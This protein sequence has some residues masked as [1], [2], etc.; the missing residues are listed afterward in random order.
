[1]DKAIVIPFSIEKIDRLRN[2]WNLYD[3]QS[4]IELLG[5]DYSDLDP[6][7]I[8]EYLEMLI[9]D[10]EV[11]ESAYEILKYELGEHLSEGQLRNLANEMEDDKMWEEYPDM[12]LHREIFKVNQLLYRA[13]NG[14]VPK[15]EAL[16]L[17]FEVKSSN[18]D[19]IAL[20]SAK[21]PDAI[22]RLIMAGSNNHSKLHR[23]YGGDEGN[24]Y[25]SDAKSILWHIGAH[26]ISS[27]K[28]ELMVTSSLYWLGSFDT[29]SEF[30]FNINLDLYKQENH[31]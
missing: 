29:E 3:Y 21:D 22:L 10:N 30:E 11:A 9:S 19:F 7:E 8:E 4:I 23:L 25:I 16:L 5:G 28:V 31:A 14:K 13:Y 15:G 27:N 12:S 26:K 17:K 24:V 1:M 2:S 18:S 6:S 20:L